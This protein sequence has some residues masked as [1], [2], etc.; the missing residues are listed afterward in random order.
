MTF[1]HVSDPYRDETVLQSPPPP[2]GFTHE[3]SGL[4]SIDSIW[5]SSENFNP[6]DSQGATFGLEALSAAASGKNYSY[7]LPPSSLDQHHR[8]PSSASQQNQQSSSQN[9]NFILNHATPDDASPPIDPRLHAEL[10]ASSPLGSPVQSRHFRASSRQS[11]PIDNE[12]VSFLLRHYSEGPGHWM[13]IFDLGRF[14]AMDV[15]VKARSCPLLLYSAASLAA[16]SLGR[17]SIDNKKIKEAVPYQTPDQ[18]VHKARTYYDSAIHLLREALA[19]ETTRERQGSRPL[20][21]GGSFGDDPSLPRTDSNE[22]M[23]TTANLCVYEFLDGSGAEWAQH[24]DGAKS[25][26]DIAKD[27]V[28]SMPAESP[29]IYR[30][31]SF[32]PRPSNKTRQ[33]I[34]WNIARQ[35]ML[36]ACEL[37]RLKP[38]DTA[39]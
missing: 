23:A 9:L 2:A 19:S 27:S 31:P 4:Q 3:D 5:Q 8:S 6:F 37:S 38:Y 10:T 32:G 1:V 16:K 15:P 36:E 14:F 39:Y 21:S 35:D 28:M 33:A 34:F 26:F 22:M 30:A 20:S 17:L 11:A 24:L 18:W 29:S 25:L 12:T 13:D 7:P